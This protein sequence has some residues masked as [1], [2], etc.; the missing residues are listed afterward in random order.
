VELAEKFLSTRRGTIILGVGAAALA[1]ILLLVYLNRYRSSLNESNQSA[2]VLV[3]KSLIEKGAP[4]NIIGTQRQFQVGTIPKHELQNGA[5]TDPSAL[6]GLVATHDIYPG[7]QLTVADFAPV[8]AGSLQ[9]NLT[10]TYR[11]ISI[12][13]DAS[14]GLMGALAPGDHVDVYVGLNQLAAAGAQP[15]IKQLMQDTLVLGTPGAG[16]SPGNVI[17]RARGPQ[18]AALAFAADNGK[19]WLVLRP[20]SGAKNVKPGLITMQRVLLGVGR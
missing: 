1:A 2:S 13:F 15:V 17:L 10:K 8:A 4:G 18:A 3:A 5:I 14:H 20:A 12:P 9:T 16:A 11:A 7:Q 19:I 6:R